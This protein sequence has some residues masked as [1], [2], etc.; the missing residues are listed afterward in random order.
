VFRFE[1]TVAA[2]PQ[3]VVAVLRGA[4][5]EGMRDFTFDVMGNGF[6][7]ITG[8]LV[9]ESDVAKVAE[10]ARHSST[11]LG[12]TAITNQGLERRTPKVAGD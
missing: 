11:F 7:R 9:R 5:T 8:Y 10:G 6:V 3:A 2:N 1:P 4:F 12:A